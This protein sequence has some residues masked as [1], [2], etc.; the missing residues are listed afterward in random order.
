MSNK[1][2]SLPVVEIRHEDKAT[3]EIQGGRRKAL[4]LKS[5]LIV[6]I[7]CATASPSHGITEI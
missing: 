5:F 6:C 1:Q 2:F 7:L 3:H 4:R